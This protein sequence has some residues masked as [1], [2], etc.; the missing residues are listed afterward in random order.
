MKTINFK[1]LIIILI[2]SF[3]N[4]ALA[5]KIRP[6]AIYKDIKY[7]YILNKDGST[8]FNYSSKLMLISYFAVN[9]LF[10]ETF[11]TY[12]PDWQTLKVTK[13]TTI[14]ADGTIVRSPV[15]AYN[16]I[17]PRFASKAAPYMNLREMV[18]T[19]TGLERNCLIDM[20][21]SINTKRGFLPGLMDKII[22]GAREPIENME[23]V[24]KVP[25]GTKLN[26][27]MANNGPQGKTYSSGGYDTYLWKIQNIPQISVESRQPSFTDFLPVLYFST[28]S[29]S[30]VV[31]HILDKENLFVLSDKAK[32]IVKDLV[33]N[34]VSD[35]EKAM[36][37]RNYVYKNIG[38]TNGNLK[39]FGYKCLPAKETFDRNVGNKMDRAVLLT[40]MCREAGINASLA[41]SSNYSSIKGELNLLNQ[42]EDC[43]VY[44]NFGKNQMPLLLDPNNWQNQLIPDYKLAVVLNK[45]KL[46]LIP[47]IK[48]NN[49]LTFSAEMEFNIDK[50]IKGFANISL[51]GNYK[52]S[53]ENSSIESRIKSILGLSDYSATVKTN[54]LAINDI[55]SVAKSVEFKSSNKIKNEGGIY[56]IDFPYSSYES[57]FHLVPNKRT[58]PYELHST[59]NEN[60]RINLKIPSDYELAYT[61][62]EINIKNKIGSIQIKLNQNADGTIDL[63]RKIEINHTLIQP[64]DYHLLYDLIAKWESKHYKSVFVR[65]K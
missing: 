52:H 40:A 56:Q 35:I 57:N 19:H 48:Q 14:M 8:T 13:S 59:I 6:D 54:N 49:S 24:I 4:I 34:Q 21:Y 32:G 55:N 28:A 64:Q 43:L 15:N 17:Q 61:F 25:K 50:S 22:I 3:V 37:L 58:T 27:Y 31:N 18:V 33:K 36:T 39:Y 29:N 46:S 1:I 63:I 53:L 51:S 12:N 23:I 7:E 47:A 30:D 9:R 41:L 60:L 20:A 10:G 2:L 5:E 62:D 16:L 11:I 65:K 44:C 45:K 42:F 38:E 26:L